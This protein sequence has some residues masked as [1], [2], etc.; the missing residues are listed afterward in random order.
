MMIGEQDFPIVL[1]DW[2]NACFG[3]GWRQ[4][5]QIDADFCGDENGIIKTVGFLVRDHKNYVVIAGTISQ[6]GT[7]YNLFQR[8]PRGLIIK[9]V[10]VRK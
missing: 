6:E 8:I 7:L 4:D 2:K 9:Q 3:D 10:V 1:V 5:Q